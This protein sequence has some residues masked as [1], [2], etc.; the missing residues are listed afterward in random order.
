MGAVRED[1]C[2]FKLFPSSHKVGV[3]ILLIFRY[4]DYLADD[5]NVTRI[6]IPYLPYLP[7]LPHLPYLHT[8][9]HRTGKQVTAHII[10][11]PNLCGQSIEICPL[12]SSTQSN[13]SCS[14]TSHNILQ[15]F[16]SPCSCTP[17]M[18]RADQCFFVRMNEDSLLLAGLSHIY[19]YCNCYQ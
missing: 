12:T 2:G 16:S 17:A 9:Y 11:I 15:V 4:F 18:P 13:Q 8:R 7:Y 1:G 14:L 19:R 10:V 5:T 6:T 3:L